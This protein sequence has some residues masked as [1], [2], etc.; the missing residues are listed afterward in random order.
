MSR[1][2]FRNK[3]IYYII[4]RDI[5]RKQE[6]DKERY[7][8]KDEIYSS[9]PFPEDLIAKSTYWRYINDYKN[10]G[11]IQTKYFTRGNV[12]F[13]IKLIKITEKGWH[14][15]TKNKDKFDLSNLAEYF[16]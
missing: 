1:L 14:F 11:F 2:R 9:I 5:V 8:S 4:F 12:S 15:Y 13:M 3:K 10:R 16:H 6:E 7:F